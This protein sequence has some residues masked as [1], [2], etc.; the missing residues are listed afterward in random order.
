[1][2]ANMETMMYNADNGKPWHKQGV[3]VDGLATAHEALE[4]SGLDWEV[5]KLPMT[6]QT[7]NGEQ[8]VVPDNYA[9]TRL[10]DN[11]VLGVVG[12]RYRPLQNRDAFE[13]FDPIVDRDEAIYETA[14]SLKGGKQIWLLAKLPAHIRI[15]NSDDLIE[16]YVM[17]TNSHDGSKP[18]IG[19]VTPIR[20]VCSNTLSLALSRG[21]DEFRIRHTK[22][23]MNKLQEAHKVLGLVN[24]VYEEVDTV[25]NR[26]AD[27]QMNGNSINEYYN[28]VFNKGREEQSTQMENTIMDVERLIDMG[29]GVDDPSFRKMRGSAWHIYNTVTEFVDH[30]KEYSKKTD[31][32]HALTFGT[33]ATIKQRAYK[34]ALKLL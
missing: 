25:F 4:K 18:V 13:F 19:K 7:P 9:N 3:S 11:K 21:G 26:M 20:V 23:M 14:G 33:G 17:L 22:T 28:N 1:M 29:A 24:K 30:Y 10:S 5:E 8:V 12:E 34:E 16:K 31:R 27:V 6:A 15:G 32:S 2:S